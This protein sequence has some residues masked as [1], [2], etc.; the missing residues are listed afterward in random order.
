MTE[1]LLLGDNGMLGSMVAS[2]LRSSGATVTTTCRSPIGSDQV[3]FDA[4]HDDVGQLFTNRSFDYVVNAIGIIKP[5]IN[6]ADNASRVTAIAVNALFPHRLASACE[7]NGAHL[8]QIATDCVYSGKEG[9]YPE[10]APHDPTDVYGKTKSLGEVSSTAAL[11]LRASII[12]P[13]VGRQ[14][15]LWEWVRS[16]PENAEI[17]GFTNHLWNGVTTFHFGKICA[18]IV[19]QGSRLSG[20]FHV[21]PAD[22]VTKLELVSSIAEA[23]ARQDIKVRATEA[24]DTIDRTLQTLHPEQN[25]E[26]WKWAGFVKEP[27]IAEMVR[28]VPL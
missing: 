27:T 2:V 23:S 20:T 19:T 13:E 16:Q 11:H 6:E 10:T 24:K 5:R 4:E 17:N 18:G 9:N 21:V 15:S 28:D 12:G 25:A 1:V 3:A 8:I 7:S 14:T 26:F 22:I